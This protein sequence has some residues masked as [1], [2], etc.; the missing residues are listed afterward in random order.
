MNDHEL[1]TLYERLQARREPGR[2]RCVAPEHL[3]R[4][5]AGDATESERLDWLDHV[6]GCPA[7]RAELNLARAVAEAGR[8]LERRP[9]PASWLA[10][11]ASVLVLVGGVTLWRGGLLTPDRVT[12]G[13][14]DR[15][16]LV[17]PTGIRPADQSRRLVWRS[18]PR[19]VRYDVEVLDSAGA[20]AFATSTADTLADLPPGALRPNVEYRW[21]VT[22]VLPDGGRRRSTAAPLRVRA[23]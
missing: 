16:T 1:R 8:G 14:G 6:A 13:D 15:V 18:V 5:A 12:R 20:P 4:L 11:A 19:A 7:C 3:M 23:P 22:A 9:I 17:G 2:G 10:L 21:L